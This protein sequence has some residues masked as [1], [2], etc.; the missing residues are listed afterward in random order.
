VTP[1]SFVSRADG[2]S[3]QITCPGKKESE[4]SMTDIRWRKGTR[5]SGWLVALLLAGAASAVAT[6]GTEARAANPLPYTGVSMA[7]GEF[8][9]PQKGV[10]PI[11]GT[12]FSYPTADE[13]A[14]FASRGMNIFRL[15]F[16]WETLQPEA[17]GPFN[18]TE[19]ARLKDTVKAATDRGLTVIL[20]PHNYARYYGDIVG[21]PAVGDD[22]FA[23]FWQRLATEFKND[24]H[25]WFGLVNEPHDMPTEQW[26]GAANAAI[27]AIRG[28][29]AHNRITVPGNSW[30]GAFSWE[31]TWY[32]TPNGTAML[33]IVD[34]DNNYLIEVH[35]YLDSDNSGTKPVVMSPTIGSERLRG[36]TAWCRKNHKKAFLG[37][38]AAPD[39]PLGKQAIEDMLTYMETNRDVWVGF[40]WWAAGSRWGEYMFTLEPKGGRD[41]PQMAWLLPHLHRARRG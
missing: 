31:S 37:E 34:P 38:F 5:Q 25:V 8:Y 35:Q 6:P 18:P 23:D 39:S 27:A 3:P 16:L 22:A 32:G 11:Y 9:K 13:Y 7:G 29:G 15:Q 10:A 19:I 41:R 21:G 2:A 12:Q 1:E 24:P 36:F 30:T 26:V 33:N 28:T 40:T 20:D 17:K 4:R 14:Y